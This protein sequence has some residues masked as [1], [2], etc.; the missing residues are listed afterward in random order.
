MS[1]MS[2]D[3]TTTE[4]AAAE[5]SGCRRTCRTAPKEQSGSQ[6][7]ARA[8]Q[9]ILLSRPHCMDGAQPGL[10]R[11][12]LLSK[13]PAVPARLGPERPAVV[14]RTH[15]PARDGH[16][17]QRPSPVTWAG[18]TRSGASKISWAKA[19]KPTTCSTSATCRATRSSPAP[20]TSMSSA[21]AATARSSS[22]TPSTT[23]CARPASRTAS[24][25]SG[26]RN[27]SARS[28]RKTAAT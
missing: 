4:S 14:P 28:C 20:S 11:L 24:R 15:L 2:N 21:S 17:R 1:I 13:R 12:H 25:C 27:S 22:S 3:E 9:E 8:G 18:C 7:G 26:S 23:A 19:N 5:A 6:E 16:R 10:D